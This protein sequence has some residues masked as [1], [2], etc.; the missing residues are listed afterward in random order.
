MVSRHSQVA[1]AA[2]L[3]RSRHS[4]LDIDVKNCRFITTFKA[5]N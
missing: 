5:H 4:W 1:L 2:W 3:L